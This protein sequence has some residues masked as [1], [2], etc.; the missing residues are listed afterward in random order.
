MKVCRYCDA[1]AP[2]EAVSCA[3]CGAR[4]FESI[5]ENCGTRFSSRY[6]PDC[7]AEAGEKPRICPNCGS[8]SMSAFC[9]DCG[10]SLIPQTE[11]S[12]PRLQQCVFT[13]GGSNIGLVILTLFVPFIGAWILLMG[14][15]FS[16]NLKLFALVYSG[17]ASAALLFQR[18]W[19]P[20]LIYF[21]PI[22]AYIIKLWLRREKVVSGG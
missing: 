10:V 7:G 4:E 20:G 8:R 12:A 21:A 6:C 3:N 17:L 13:S 1:S 5:C 16:R 9:P 14:D 2:Y 18:N 15:R 22:A 19:V 11:K